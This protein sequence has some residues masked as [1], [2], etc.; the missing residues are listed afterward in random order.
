M[1]KYID[2]NHLRKKKGFVDGSGDWV[3]LIFVKTQKKES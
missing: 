3:E 2:F 1:C